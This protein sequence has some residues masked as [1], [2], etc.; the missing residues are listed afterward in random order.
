[1]DKGSIGEDIDWYYERGYISERPDAE[2][3]VD[4]SFCRYATKVLGPYDASARQDR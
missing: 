2:E 1:V 4:D 3:I